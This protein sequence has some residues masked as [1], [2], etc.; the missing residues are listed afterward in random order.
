MILIPNLC[1]GEFDRAGTG[2]GVAT[3][4][5]AGGAGNRS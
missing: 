2:D 3:I 5:W 4:L 1:L